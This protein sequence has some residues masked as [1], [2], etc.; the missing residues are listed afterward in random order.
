MIDEGLTGYSF[1]CGDTR[2]LGAALERALEMR[3]RPDVVAALARKTGVH[4]PS[5]AA[6]ATVAAVE[7][8]LSL[9]R[10]GR[11]PRPDT[12]PVR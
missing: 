2:Q 10:R 8:M 4:S 9:R 1:A 7:G 11:S 3:G 12:G 6:D 5:H